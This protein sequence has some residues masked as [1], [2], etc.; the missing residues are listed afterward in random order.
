MGPHPIFESDFDCLTETSK[1]NIMADSKLKVEKQHDLGVLE[2][3]DEFEEFPAEDW[4][5]V[6]DDEKVD[7]VWEEN[8]EDDNIEDDFSIQLRAELEAKGHKLEQLVV[9]KSEQA[10]N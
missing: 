9:P 3:D 6:N 8:W 2:E 1:K 7:E 5:Q 10:E 4:K